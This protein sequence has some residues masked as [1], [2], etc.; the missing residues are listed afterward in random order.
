MHQEGS[1]ELQEHKH[2]P[3][4]LQLLQQSLSPCL[5]TIV[6]PEGKNNLQPQR[7]CRRHR[8]A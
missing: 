5:P 7:E 6:A 3:Q 2:K 1:L 8:H 4:N